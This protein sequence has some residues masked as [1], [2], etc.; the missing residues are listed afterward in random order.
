MVDDKRV[1]FLMHVPIFWYTPFTAP[2][3]AHVLELMI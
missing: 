1:L 3:L 2:E